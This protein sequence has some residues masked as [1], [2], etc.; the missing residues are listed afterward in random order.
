MSNP[1]IPS[2]QLARSENR[3]AISSGVNHESSRGV[4]QLP[5]ISFVA[6]GS[7]GT[8]HDTEVAVFVE[9]E[10]VEVVRRRGRPPCPHVARAHHV[11]ALLRDLDESAGAPVARDS[12]HAGE[13]DLS[14]RVD[15]VGIGATLVEGV[16]PQRHEDR[17]AGVGVDS[18]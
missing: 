16:I 6:C 5:P 12:I 18:A 1:I 15:I 7:L 10:V 11:E 8:E 17:T 9:R 13:V 14:R 3:R 4:E 2:T